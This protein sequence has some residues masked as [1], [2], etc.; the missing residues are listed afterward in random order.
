[1]NKFFYKS[2][3]ILPKVTKVVL[4]LGCNTQD[5]SNFAS[6]LLALSFI[7]DQTGVFT[8]S[9]KSNILLKIRKGNL[10]GCKVTL[11]NFKGFFFLLRN[12]WSIFPKIKNF[13]GFN[14]EQQLKSNTFSY[15]LSD[16]LVFPEVESYYFLLKGLSKLNLTLTTS[17]K[18]EKEMI[19]LVKTIQ[20][21]ES[22]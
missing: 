4:N 9:R 18:S 2:T 7:T 16:S 3:K 11:K 6:S 1:M 13:K 19:F 21:P 14:L 8:A 20:I 5:I 22:L 10:T 15:E 17:C 12:I